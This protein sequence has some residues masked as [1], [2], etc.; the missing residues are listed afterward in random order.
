MARWT[1][2]M[3]DER[4]SIF[5]LVRVPQQ[6]RRWLRPDLSQIN[7]M[8]LVFAC[9]EGRPPSYVEERTFLG[10]YE[11]NPDFGRVRDVT[12]QLRKGGETQVPR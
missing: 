1:Y 4:T 2:A 11:N 9:L 7:T 12:E 6:C 5:N 10:V 8:R 3:I